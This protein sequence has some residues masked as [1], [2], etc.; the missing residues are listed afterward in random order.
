[1]RTLEAVPLLESNGGN[2]RILKAEI[3]TQLPAHVVCRAI[4]TSWRTIDD[5]QWIVMPHHTSVIKTAHP[6]RGYRVRVIYR[7]TGIEDL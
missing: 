4:Q 3:A 7:L 2:Y 6:I 5:W 1:M